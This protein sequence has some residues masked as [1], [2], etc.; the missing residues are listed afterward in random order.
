MTGERPI[1]KSAGDKVG[2]STVRSGDRSSRRTGGS[3]TVLAGI[4]R[5]VDSH[6]TKAPIEKLA[7][8]IGGVFVPRDRDITGHV[9]RMPNGGKLRGGPF[10]C[11]VGAGHLLP[12]RIS[13]LPPTAIMVE[14]PRRP[15]GHSG[16]NGEETLQTAHKVRTVVLTG[17]RSRA[18]CPWWSRRSACG[19]FR[20]RSA[21]A[22]AA[23]ESPSS[24]PARAIV[25]CAGDRGIAAGL[26]GIFGNRKAAALSRPWAADASQ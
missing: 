20:R 10:A 6:G 19:R 24:I 22:A 1:D 11:G 8:K 26:R 18:A 12:V 15:H 9:R 16:E 13:A 3:D 4:V 17:E 21:G 25:S 14:R 23:A 7:D 2:A 5:M